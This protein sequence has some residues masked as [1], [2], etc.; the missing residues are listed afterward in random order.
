M[1]EQSSL[2]FWQGLNQAMYLMDHPDRLPAI[3]KQAAHAMSSAAVV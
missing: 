1:I 2:L 3:A